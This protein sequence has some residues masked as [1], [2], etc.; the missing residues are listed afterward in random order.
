V[1]VRKRF[2]TA[3]R[4]FLSPARKEAYDQRGSLL[5]GDDISAMR[6]RNPDWLP[7]MPKW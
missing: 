6:E 7:H 4:E 3:Y 5:A 1:T 2:Q